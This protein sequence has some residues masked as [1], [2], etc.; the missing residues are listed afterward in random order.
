MIRLIRDYILTWF[1]ERVLSDLLANELT[2]ADK[3]TINTVLERTF[4]EGA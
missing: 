2:D 3:A 4:N 1:A